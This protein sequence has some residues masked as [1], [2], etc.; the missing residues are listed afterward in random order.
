MGLCEL[1]Q[2]L[3]SKVLVNGVNK[4]LHH[5]HE[6]FKEAVFGSKCYL[7]CQVWDSMNEE[8]K[9]VAG[10][11]GF[12]GI[13]YDILL[14]RTQYGEENGQE[15]VLA[16]LFIK[17]GEDLWDC[18]QYDTVGGTHV[19]DAGQFAILNPFGR[20]RLNENSGERTR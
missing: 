7:C 19:V 4:A 8:Q 5:N 11:P 1:C 20:W 12:E 13:D 6:T 16:T 15:P 14:G 17:H 10:R 2:S 9:E 3:S 18:E